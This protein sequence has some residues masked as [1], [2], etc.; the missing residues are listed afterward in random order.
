M[1]TGDLPI[2]PALQ[3]SSSFELVYEIP[4]ELKHVERTFQHPLPFR[5]TLCL[6]HQP[7]SSFPEY[8]VVVLDVGGFHIVESR[9]T[10]YY[11][12]LLSDDSPI[13]P[14]LYKLP[15]LETGIRTILGQNISVDVISIGEHLHFGLRR[16]LLCP[17]KYFL[18]HP[19][20]TLLS[21]FSNR[22]CHKEVC[23]SLYT[24]ICP[25]ITFARHV[26]AAGLNIFL[27]FYKATYFIAF[28]R[29][30]SEGLYEVLIHL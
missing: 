9:V 5:E 27:F 19:P 10:L 28:K 11:P 20:T 26:W 15:I 18:H 4:I 12:F 8:P 7:T 13:L 3:G 23:T 29:C 25:G 22:K 1:S 14:D 30:E 24:G 2:L 21:P 6:P 17:F 16:R